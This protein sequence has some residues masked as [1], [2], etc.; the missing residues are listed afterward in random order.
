MGWTA[1]PVAGLLAAAWRAGLDGGVLPS[2]LQV[3]HL[4]PMTS[5]HEPPDLHP[6][7]GPHASD[8]AAAAA[9]TAKQAAGV[10]GDAGM[11][12]SPHTCRRCT[13]MPAQVVMLQ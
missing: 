6:M 2:H 11:L 8:L 5:P 9:Q 7:E 3:A 1:A 4:H 13:N 12:Q 10:V